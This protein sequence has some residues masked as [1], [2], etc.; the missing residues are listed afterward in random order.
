MGEK[1]AQRKAR[2]QFTIKRVKGFLN[3]LRKSKRGMF[4]FAIIIIAI[5]VALAAPLFTPYNPI[6]TNNLSADWA[7]PSWERYLPGGGGLSLNM[8]PVVE[9]SLLESPNALKEFNFTV[10]GS[11]QAVSNTA[12]VN[13]TLPAFYVLISPTSVVMSPGESLNVSSNV[14]GGL[15]PYTYHWYL[16]GVP[17]SL[18]GP[19]A[20]SS[21]AT[22]TPSWP[23]GVLTQKVYVRVMDK[24]NSIA[25][26][27]NATLSLEGLLVV[28][29]SPANV[30]LDVGQPQTFTSNVTGGSGLYSYQWYLNGVAVPTATSTAWTFTPPAAGSYSIFLKVIDNVA[31]QAPQGVTVQHSAFGTAE[32]SSGSLEIICQ[33]PADF[34]LNSS[35]T[36]QAT[37]D[38]YY[39]YSGGPGSFSPSGSILISGMEG[40][41]VTPSLVLGQTWLTVT[42]PG[43]ASYRQTQFYF[44]SEIGGNPLNYA[45][46]TFEASNY[47]TASL[48]EP[49]LVDYMGWQSPAMSTLQG[50]SVVSGLLQRLF[51]KA[52]TYSYGIDLTATKL[53]S[54]A[55]ANIYVD[56]LNLGLLGTSWGL[57]GTDEQG[58]DV[59]TQLVY[60]TQISL[61]VGLVAA[62]LSVAIGLL[63][64]LVAAY[65]GG[66]VD[67]V[68]MRF[69][70]ALLVLPG[71]PLMIVLI[72]VVSAGQY[73]LT[74]FI[75]VIGFLGW[76]GF[77]R[78][79]R[80]QVLSL[81][82]RPYVEAAKAVG[83]GTPYILWR[84]I[85]P[86]VIVLVY[87][88]LA[89]S[90]PGAIVA[91]AAFSFLGFIDHAHMS[92][93]R[94]LNDA[95]T[96]PGIWWVM[97]PPGLAIAVLSLSFILIGYAIDDILNPRLRT[98]R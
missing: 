70:D 87:V 27:N 10:T 13:R 5:I 57:L 47:T 28:S 92:W 6:Y 48:T 22:L 50:Q 53:S 39:P 45:R 64:G 37:T 7:A 56:N 66:I 36:I 77:A 11:T 9:S 72:T 15:A 58:R 90:V 20:N 85:L 46:V 93:G 84:H 35:I 32:N 25:F 79:V 44:G 86:N 19:G 33:F 1:M 60:G 4:G 75:T 49:P 16:N 91:E 63:V 54:N 62:I 43:V 88:T 78:I 59:F 55:H 14:S 18:R 95:T 26:C 40:V 68:L 94:M 98:R 8:I 3:S 97:I 42:S 41:A 65:S 61:F 83:A 29:I 82:E 24:R 96:N 76:M 21:T 89:L 73:N 30:T 51:P 69:T 52:A 12:T 71:L 67:E 2:L 38:F 17:F 34:P 81:K 31:I 23:T 80:S 74:I